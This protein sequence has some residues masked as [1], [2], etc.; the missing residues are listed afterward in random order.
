LVW[1]KGNEDYGADAWL[2]KKFLH[3]EYMDL[4][5]DYRKI[6]LEE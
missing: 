1:L 3:M 6:P 2:N 5:Q 4:K